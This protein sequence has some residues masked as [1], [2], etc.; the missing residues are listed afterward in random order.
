MFGAF[1]RICTHT[2]L[3]MESLSLIAWRHFLHRATDE[4][5]YRLKNKRQKDK[6]RL[7]RILYI[8]SLLVAFRLKGIKS[9]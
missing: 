4:C 1:V 3:R 9:S 6:K 2:M 7:I 5:T 8:T